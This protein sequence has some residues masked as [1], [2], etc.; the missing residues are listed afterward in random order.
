MGTFVSLYPFG[1]Y[2]ASLYLLAAVIGVVNSIVITGWYVQSLKRLCMESFTLIRYLLPSGTSGECL[3]LWRDSNSQPFFHYLS[4]SHTLGSIFSAALA[5]PFLEGEGE[6]G[7]GGWTFLG[8]GGIR[9]FFTAYGTVV[10][11]LSS[12]FWYLA[13]RARGHQQQQ[14]DQEEE[15]EEAAAA[16]DGE[17]DFRMT[18]LL[19]QLVLLFNVAAF[20][21]LPTT[22]V[23][24]QMS[25]FGANSHLNLTQSQSAELAVYYWVPFLVGKVAGIVASLVLSTEIII[26]ACSPLT[27]A[28]SCYILWRQGCQGLESWNDPFCLEK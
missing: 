28:P 11:T 27:L 1:V 17:D 8:L 23:G 15:K 10:F 5:V 14:Q 20:L 16:A 22:T 18:P 25:L 3:R 26:Y 19:W 2:V 4:L 21:Q 12:G 24:Q 6:D 7:G 9:G 13:A